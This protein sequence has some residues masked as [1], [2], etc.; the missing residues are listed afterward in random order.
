MFFREDGHEAARVHRGVGRRGGVAG[1][2]ARS[3]WSIGRNALVETR[4][5]TSDLARLYKDAVMNEQLETLKKAREEMRKQFL[6]YAES[7]AKGFQR[8]QTYGDIEE[9]V[10]IADAIEALDKAIEK[11]WAAP[12]G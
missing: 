2:G 11:G 9:I 10:K 4:W 7:L 1:G 8:G 6:G 3:D 12:A 5:S